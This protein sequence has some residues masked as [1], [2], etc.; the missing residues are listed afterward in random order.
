VRDLHLGLTPGTP[1][2][3]T[4]R[5]NLPEMYLGDVSALHDAELVTGLTPCP[6]VRRLNGLCGYPAAQR[7]QGR[8]GLWCPR[9]GA[10]R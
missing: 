2:H 3:Y 7:F 4:Q 5:G 9:C 10:A 8:A 1:R 6:A